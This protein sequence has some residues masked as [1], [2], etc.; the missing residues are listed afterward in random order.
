MGKKWCSLGVL[1]I[2]L[3]AGASAVPAREVAGRTFGGKGWNQSEVADSLALPVSFAGAS[4]GAIS[5]DLQRTGDTPA[6]AGETVFSLLDRSGVQVLRL[7]VSWAPAAGRNPTLTFR[8]PGK[9]DEYRHHGIGLWGPVVELDRPVARGESIHVDLTWDDGARKYAVSVDGKEQTRKA[10]D[11]EPGRSLS[12]AERERVNSDR[13]RLGQPKAF[14]SRPLGAF[15]SGVVSV[16]LGSYGPPVP[17]PDG[18]RALPPGKRRPYLRSALVESFT[19]SVDDV[20]A[21]QPPAISSVGHDAAKVSGFSG[22][23][24]AGDTLHVTL[25]GN[26]GATATFD[27]VHYPD[28][29]GRITLD[30]RGWGVYLEEKAFYEPGEVNLRDVESYRVYASTVPFDPAAPGVEPVEQLE[31]GVQSYTFEYLQV[32]TPYYLAAVALMRDGTTRTVLAPITRQP[33]TET[34]PGVY[35]G[36]YRAGWQDRYPRAVVVGRLERLGAETTL[37]DTTVLAIDPGLTVAVAAEPNELKADEVS[38]SKVAVTVT[39]ANGKAVPGHKVKFLLATTSTYTGV[40]GGGDFADQVGGRIT[41]DRWLETDLF[42]RVELTYVAGFA[43]KTAI[44]VARDM[45]SNSTGSAWV[46]TYITAAAQLELEPAQETA[47]MAAGY[48]IAVTSSDEWLTADGRS[49]ARITAR[50]TLGGAPVEGHTVDFGVASGAGSIRTVKDITDRKGE[51]RAVYTAGKKIGIV[52]I[53]ATDRTAEISGTVSIELRSDAPAK[54]AITLNPEKLPADG[55]SRAELSVLVTDINDNPNDNTEVEY[56]IASGG[57]E[58]RDDK[59]LTGKN[60]ES[61]THY[62]A[63]RTAGTVT[64]EITVRSTVPTEAELAKARNLAVAV[65]DYNFF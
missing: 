12:P 14:D 40:V 37:T 6:A 62:T 53:T 47:A 16:Q 1:G 49:Q 21:S 64:F 9:G 25:E 44:I 4:R 54:I 17:D 28:L 56:A 59:G 10:G 48:E 34:E 3:L 61:A 41:Q 20:P 7:Q 22:K 31:A 5:F 26:P 57:G 18:A 35:G 23:L 29:G 42:G 52:L 65:T 33:L 2:W 11:D 60:G 15:L 19:A 58:L 43:A 13:E 50:V 39:D 30:W 27:L 32:D 45:V 36:S 24:V 51:A 46:K 55:R 38:R 63:G 8:G